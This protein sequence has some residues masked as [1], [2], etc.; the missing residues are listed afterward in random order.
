MQCKLKLFDNVPVFHPPCVPGHN[1]ND[2]SNTTTF[3][4]SSCKKHKISP[5]GAAAQFFCL[6]TCVFVGTNI[7]PLLPV[8]QWRTRAL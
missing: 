8:L 5:T 1:K 7:K 3:R 6:S 4:T 2:N